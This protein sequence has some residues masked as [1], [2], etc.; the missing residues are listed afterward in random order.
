LL[1]DKTRIP[2]IPVDAI[3]EDRKMRDILMKNRLV[4]FRMLIV[5]LE[6]KRVGIIFWLHHVL[7]PK[8]NLIHHGWC[9][10]FINGR[11]LVGLDLFMGE[12]IKDFLGS[13]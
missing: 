12:K 13:L 11:E 9:R 8:N 3:H 1:C 2:F 10:V 5:F 7:L 6:I 4:S